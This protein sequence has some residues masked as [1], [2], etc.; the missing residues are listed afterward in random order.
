MYKYV[1][2]N[3]LSI[4]DV[5]VKSSQGGTVCIKARFSLAIKVEAL[6][7]APS[8]GAESLSSPVPTSP[9]CED[10]SS[11]RMVLGYLPLDSVIYVE[12][13]CPETQPADDGSAEPPSQGEQ[14]QSINE[15]NQEELTELSM[16]IRFDCG[17]MR[18]NFKRDNQTHFLASIRGS[19]HLD[20]ITTSEFVAEQSMFLTSDLNHHFKFSDLIEVNSSSPSAKGF[21]LTANFYNSEFEAFRNTTSRSF[22]RPPDANS[23]PFNH[24]NKVD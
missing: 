11:D 1:G 20:S 12:D 18:F 2:V 3:D 10:S 6:L 13:S 15:L 22:I 7:E 16:S 21:I 5:V 17:K 23:R 24:D 19:V 4:N 14:S 9:G 8:N